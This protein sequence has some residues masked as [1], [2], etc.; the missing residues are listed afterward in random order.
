LIAALNFAT[1]VARFMA[2]SSELKG[3]TRTYTVTGQ[4]FFASS[5][6]FTS[7][8]DFARRWSAW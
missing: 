2:V 7:H 5:D 4:V 6:R 3:D 8:F 1:K